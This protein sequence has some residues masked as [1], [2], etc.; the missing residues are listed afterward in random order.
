MPLTLYRLRDESE[1]TQ[2]WMGNASFAFLAERRPAEYDVRDFSAALSPADCPPGSVIVVKMIGVLLDRVKWVFR[3]PGVRDWIAAGIPIVFDDSTEASISGA[4]QWKWFRRTLQDENL[5][6]G[7]FVWLQQNVRGPEDC[8]ATFRDQT[9]HRVESVVVHYWMHRLRIDAVDVP[10]RPE[11]GQREKRFLCLNY[12]LRTHRAALL[13]WLLRE[14][15]VER[16]LVSVA[17]QMPGTTNFRWKTFEEFETFA[18]EEFPGFA[19]EIAANRTLMT[20]AQVLGEGTVQ[21]RLVRWDIHARAG[22][23]LVSETEMRSGDTLRFTEKTLKALAA[24]HPV[25]VAGN[26]G[27]L[28]L[29]REHGFQTF[30]PWID[31]SYDLIEGREERLRAVLAQ[32][33]RLVEMSEDAFDRLMAEMEPVLAFNHRHFMEGLPAIMDG[34]HAAFQRAVAGMIAGA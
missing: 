20:Q 16:G 7:R 29:L 3:Q 32:A 5:P 30:S 22:F 24:W 18:L 6:P 13:G 23:S 28:G 26:A 1:Q 14:G 10:G 25:V 31:E 27:V 8:A 2:K 12:K 11:A 33:K 17:W 34:Q 21:A 9:H 4:E 19:A 15:L